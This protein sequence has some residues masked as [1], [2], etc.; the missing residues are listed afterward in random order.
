MLNYLVLQS[1]CCSN[2]ALLCNNRKHSA[3]QHAYNHVSIR[4]IHHILD[5]VSTF[6]LHSPREIQATFS[7]H[8]D[9]LWSWDDLHE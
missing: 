8:L 5:P 4:R 6:S 3:L 9:L 7:S 2:M 1:L